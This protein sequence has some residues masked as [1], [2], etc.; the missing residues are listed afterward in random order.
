MHHPRLA[1]LAAALLAAVV[2]AS[3]AG[4]IQ[5]SSH[6]APGP[7]PTQAIKIEAGDNYFNPETLT[8]TA[9]ET[10]TV[11]VINTGLRPHDWTVE[12]LGVSTGVMGVGEIVHTTFTVPDAPV[13]FVCTLHR[14]M[15]G[16][17]QIG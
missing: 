7:A 13:E 9:G 1:P 8:L 4:A 16:T 12:S 10:V 17:L 5:A 2:T 15:D 3:C 11:E 6:T 14:G